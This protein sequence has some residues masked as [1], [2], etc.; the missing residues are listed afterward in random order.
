MPASWPKPLVLGFAAAWLAVA[1][2]AAIRPAATQSSRRPRAAETGAAFEATPGLAFLEAAHHVLDQRHRTG[3]TVW[4]LRTLCETSAIEPLWRAFQAATTI[5]LLVQPDADCEELARAVRQW[6][7][8]LALPGLHLVSATQPGPSAR[9]RLML[10][11]VDRRLRALLVAPSW[12][13][14]TRGPLRSYQLA[15]L[16]EEGAALEI[17]AG[18]I[19]A[20]FSDWY[21]RRAAV[22]ADVAQNAQADR[23]RLE[24]A[25]RFVAVTPDLDALATLTC[26]RFVQTRLGISPLRLLYGVPSSAV[27][28]APVEVAHWPV[29]YR[30]G[31][32]G[33]PAARW[34]TTVRSTRDG[35]ELRLVQLSS[36]E[37]TTSRGTPRT[38]LYVDRYEVTVA[39]YIRYLLLTRGDWRWIAAAL[40]SRKI[41]WASPQTRLSWYE[42]VR[43]LQWAGRELPSRAIWQRLA[44]RSIRLGTATVRD[45]SA[46]TVLDVEE[47]GICNVTRGVSE[48][49]SGC[50]SELE[51]ARPAGVRRFALRF[52]PCPYRWATPLPR[53]VPGR[54]ITPRPLPA[55]YRSPWLGFRGAL[56]VQVR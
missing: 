11:R 17:R 46:Y 52:G 8:H 14:V 39:Q 23:V 35:A 25:I 32:P 12:P 26:D 51:A 1:V 54:V 53:D 20:A 7:E 29:G 37:A 24:A 3:S 48:W 33:P 43:Y 21:R 47:H 28:S 56:R 34:P 5:E 49:L 45:Q 18:F 42:A 13:F 41:D 9:A 55:E 36:S 15:E 27:S 6:L 38:L 40:G 44:R 22:L 31:A 16:R 19:V 4:E 10:Q 50:A 30:P 2:A